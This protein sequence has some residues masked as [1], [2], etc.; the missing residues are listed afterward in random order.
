M[1]QATSPAMLFAHKPTIPFM[2]KLKF[3]PYCNANLTVQKT[4]EKDVFTLHIG[5]FRTRET[6]LCCEDCGHFANYGSEELLDIVPK[7]CQF[8]Y[9]VMVY[10]GKA[11]FLR[12]RCNHEIAA[13]LA[14]RNIPISSGEID[15]LAKKFIVHLAIAH[16]RN[17]EKIKTAMRWN[18]GFILHLDSTCDNGSPMLMSGIDS[19]TNIVLGSVKISSEK[20]DLIVPFLRDI[21]A[22]FGNPL[23]VVQDMAKG[24]MNA[25]EEVFDSVSIFICHFHFLRDIG[26]DL[27]GNDYDII[28][29]RL[30]KHAIVGE[31]NN[32]TKSLHIV[33]DDHPHLIDGIYDCVEEGQIVDSILELM[34]L[35]S[36]YT[37]IHW[38]LE[39]QNQ[40]NGY[41]FPF[42]R[43]HVDFSKR[44]LEGD[45]QIDALKILELR[46]NW[47]D[48]KPF[49]KLSCKL[50]KVVDDKVFKAAIS[51]IQATIEVFDKLRDAMRIAKPSGKKG[52]NDHGMDED[53]C[54][55]KER[56]TEF[57]RWLVEDLKLAEDK[58]YTGF[59][60]QVD[61]YWD[62][63][64][65]DAI[66]VETSSG[67]IR[68][69]P[70]RTNNIMEHFFRDFKRDNI[71]KTGNNSIGKTIRAMIAETPLVKNLENPDYMRIILGQ[72]KTLE[73]VFALIDSAEVR[74]ILKKSRITDD[75]ISQKIK[76][77]IVRK[78]L[79]ERIVT[80][81]R[82]RLSV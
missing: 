60:A 7:R 52:L 29:Q 51:R 18:G 17:A 9:D 35:V 31:L 73:E 20:A 27:F 46:G 72:K 55:I 64:F 38:M 3:C 6:V 1:L 48:N 53:M 34:P 76:E 45:K 61:K 81:F 37:L 30:R 82:K 80:S 70:Q 22:K 36:C 28:R 78:D 33:I 21:K 49:Y 25:V 4:R 10:I 50:K 41:G 75:T 54:T 68:I 23:A 19:I 26:K 32:L 8:G 63:L 13:E 43:K 47:K 62:K 59:I 15:Y 16:S 14:T 57:R 67:K 58:D 71:R 42:D 2:P 40:G 65:A 74:Q 5:V 66:E 39:G 56:V 24:T 11:M 12:H 44:L 79:P 77:I 69:Q